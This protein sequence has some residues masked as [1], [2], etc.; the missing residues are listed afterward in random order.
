MKNKNN[1]STNLSLSHKLSL[2]KQNEAKSIV[3]EAILKNKIFMIQGPYSSVRNC[4]R[5]RGWVEKFYRFS[6]H[7]KPENTDKAEE[8]ED[9][10]YN[11]CQ[12]P[13]KEKDG[14]YAY[15]HRLLVNKEP[16]LFWSIRKDSLNQ[17]LIAKNQILNHFSNCIFTTKVGLNSHLQ[18][19]YWHEEHYCHSFY[20]RVYQLVKAEEKLTFEM[21]FIQTACVSLLKIIYC[22][23]ADNL[24]SSSNLPEVIIPDDIFTQAFNTCACQISFLTHNDL[25]CDFSINIILPHNFQNLLS[26]YYSV[27]RYK[28]RVSIKDFPSRINQIANVLNQLSHLCPQYHMEGCRNVWVLKPGAMSR[29]RGVMCLD[30]LEAILEVVQGQV[31]TNDKKYV[32]QKYIGE[33]R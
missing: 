23:N 17:K 5:E 29:G 8:N 10:D 30:S 18:D 9:L 13:W 26:I 2:A 33:E 24:Q 21:D 25:D 1:I 4:L 3:N 16:D 12:P 19:S 14:L 11:D 22:N 6:L 32:L 7:N 27:R 15:M 20:P 31:L 28:G